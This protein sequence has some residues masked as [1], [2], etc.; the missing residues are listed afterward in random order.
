[1]QLILSEEVIRARLRALGGQISG[2]YR[3]KTPVVIGI[4]KGAFIFVADLVR[5]LSVEVEV[6]FIRVASYGDA[7]SSSGRCTISKPAEIP[8][9]GRDVLLVEDIVDTGNTLDFLRE[10]LAAAGAASVR[11][12]VFIDKAERRCRQVA[13]DYAAFT[14]E[15]GFLVG[16]GL[17]RAERQR[18][19]P[20]VYALA[21]EEAE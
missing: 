19:L 15:G 3:G 17:D 2:D 10:T 21:G 16:Y 12:C 4:L 8:L 13:I 5:Q 6:D 20:A 9:A 7:T 18:H 14:V 11:T 1:M